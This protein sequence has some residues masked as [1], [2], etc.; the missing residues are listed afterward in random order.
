MNIKFEDTA[1]LNLI[2]KIPICFKEESGNIK[3]EL[4]ATQ[5]IAEG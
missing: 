3:W 1:V 2:V 4:P 5:P